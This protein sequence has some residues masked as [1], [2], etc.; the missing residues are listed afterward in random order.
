[1][2]QRL[3]SGIGVLELQLVI[4]AFVVEDGDAFH[5]GKQALEQAKP[6]AHEIGRNTRKASRVSTGTPQAAQ[7]FFERIATDY[8]DRN[9]LPLLFRR[10]QHRF[11]R[12]EKHVDLQ[13]PNLAA[14]N[15]NPVIAALGKTRFDDQVSSFLVSEV[16]Q[17]LAKGSEPLLHSIGRWQCE[18]TNPENLSRL[19]RVGGRHTQ[20]EGNGKCEGSCEE[21]HRHVRPPVPDHSRRSCLKTAPQCASAVSSKAGVVA[22][23]VWMASAW[24]EK[25]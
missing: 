16:A 2:S 17:G 24:Q 14:N 10:E 9:I 8:D 20:D 21:F 12:R 4:V 25:M 15:R 22:L 3:G 23:H 5:P 13:P 7:E 1:N 11:P 18:N 6:F 19:L